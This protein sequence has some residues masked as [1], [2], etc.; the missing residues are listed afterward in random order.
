MEIILGAV[1]ALLVLFSLGL[2][3][4]AYADE[5]TATAI[6]QVSAPP[7]EP[8]APPELRERLAE[9]A[10]SEPPKQLSPGAFCY[11]IAMPPDRFEY[12]CPACHAKT[13]VANEPRFSQ[14]PWE[15]EACR[16]LVKEIKGLDIALTETGFCTKCN[17]DA[18]EP[19]IGIR[20][21]YAPDRVHS[22]APVTA[23][24]LVLLKEFMDGKDKHDR[25]QGGEKPLRDY[26]K[27]LGELL[28]TGPVG[29]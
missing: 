28:G 17:P 12:V 13:L 7:V 9:L 15:L 22:V 6:T 11:N 29:K 3:G 27:R 10:R 20:I 2:S 4:H 23:D 24:D 26:T 25:G 8:T 1:I 19:V 18:K 14:M 16:R 21:R 5:D